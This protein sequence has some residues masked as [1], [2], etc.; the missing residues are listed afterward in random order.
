MKYP[1]YFSVE[2][3]T[4]TR[5]N[6]KCRITILTGAEVQKLIDEYEA[7]EAKAEA[8][9]KEKEKATAKS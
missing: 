2:L 6:N 9:K 8:E 1:F 5:V 7:E 3:A 4:L